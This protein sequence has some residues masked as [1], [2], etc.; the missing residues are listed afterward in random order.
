MHETHESAPA[1]RRLARFAAACEPSDEAFEAATLRLL[2]LI[3]LIFAAASLRNRPRLETAVSF[4]GS[5]REATAIGSSAPVSAA[6]AALLN[7]SFAHALEADDTHIASVMHGSCVVVPASLAAAEKAGANGRTL[8]RAIVIGWE[9]LIRIGLAFPG[10][11]LR[12]GFQATAVGGPFGAALSVGVIRGLDEDQLANALG[13]AGSQCGGLFEFLRNGSTS[14]WLHGGWPALSGLAAAEFAAA[15]LTGPDTILDGACGVGAAFARR[16]DSA[17][18]LAVAMADLG[19]TWHIRDVAAKLYPTCHFI[20]PFIESLIRLLERV[21]ASAIN[22]ITCHVAP[23]MA[24]LICEPWA[25]K[26]N[27]A[28]L[29]QAKWSLPY[30]LAAVLAHGRIGIET[31]DRPCLDQSVL[32]LAKR[33]T[34]V[35]AETDFP[36]H[37]PAQVNVL[38]IDGTE[39]CIRVADVLG[40][41]DR[42]LMRDA[43]LQKF[44]V[45]TED[46]LVPGGVDSIVSAVTGLLNDAPARQ[47]GAALR[48]A[49][50]TDDHIRTNP[51]RN[52]SSGEMTVP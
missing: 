32:E 10:D 46:I 27:P 13:I 43:I 18:A 19:K 30:C 28:T 48:A 14:K 29:Y 34:W 39:H 25:E 1:A 20:Q 11:F 3:G 6:A 37:Y 38:L 49:V 51:D 7:G 35:P 50:R 40:C 31:F 12:H 9:A 5:A 47:F 24:R 52:E 36:R 21:P 8:L 45:T 16:D 17:D 4:L 26:L 22:K 33:V 42:P 2:D 44:S 23:G 15:G 41:P